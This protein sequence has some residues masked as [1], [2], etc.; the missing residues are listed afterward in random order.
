MTDQAHHRSSVWFVAI[1]I[2]KRAHA[3]LV[4]DP[5][6]KR[7]GIGSSGG[8]CLG[9]CVTEWGQGRRDRRW[10]EGTASR[11]RMNGGL[12]EVRRGHRQEWRENE[13]AASMT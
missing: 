13:T 1:D 7:C 12:C 4:E 3:V 11:A 5:A 8:R 10:R 2:G 9:V 6:G